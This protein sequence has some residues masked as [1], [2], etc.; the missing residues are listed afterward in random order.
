MV[1]QV[2]RGGAGR[3]TPVAR[4]L[5]S[6][7]VVALD[8][9]VGKAVGGLLAAA[10]TSDVVDASVV[11]VAGSGDRIL[12]SDPDDI[13]RLVSATGRQVAVVGC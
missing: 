5:V 3:Q 8:E 1:A 7:E 12:T 2:W 10:G 13:Q 4:L 9:P 11:L 6:V